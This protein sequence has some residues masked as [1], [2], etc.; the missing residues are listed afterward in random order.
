VR[1]SLRRDLHHSS[2][3]A[4]GLGHIAIVELEPRHVADFRNARAEAAPS[5]VR[6]ELAWLS[7]SFA[8]AVETGKASTNPCREIRRPRR[9]RRMRLITHDEYLRVYAAAG[10]S[11]R[12]AMTLAVRTLALPADVLRMGPRD[13]V[14]RGDDRAL[15]FFRGKT[16]R[17]VECGSSENSRA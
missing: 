2:H 15:R 5:H 10:A 14:R 1:W 9:E 17:C 6:N 11:V 16:K 8:W 13:I 7:A 12:A 4:A 3:Q